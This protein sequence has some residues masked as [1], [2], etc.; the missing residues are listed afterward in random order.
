MNELNENIISG[1][2]DKDYGV[3]RPST[4]LEL[5]VAETLENIERAKKSR[6]LKERDGVATSP[7]KGK[8]LA[9]EKAILSAFSDPETEGALRRAGY[10]VKLD[11]GGKGEI[12][13]IE[14]RYPDGSLRFYSN[15]K[16]FEEAMRRLRKDD[17]IH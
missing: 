8:A 5:D 3:D 15:V 2:N 9:R 16:D 11:R 7:T 13:R 17:F 10:E 4:S 1:S 12:E 14:L 6:E